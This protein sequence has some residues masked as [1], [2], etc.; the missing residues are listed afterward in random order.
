MSTTTIRP[1][2]Y[3]YLIISRYWHDRL[4]QLHGTSMERLI[5]EAWQPILADAPNDRTGQPGQHGDLVIAWQERDGAA[6]GEPLTIDYNNATIALTYLLHMP[7]EQLAH[8]SDEATEAK[9]RLLEAISDGSPSLIADCLIDLL[10]HLDDRAQRTALLDTITAVQRARAEQEQEQPDT[11]TAREKAA[12][13]A[14]VQ[15]QAAR[16]A[17]ADASQLAEQEPTDANRAALAAALAATGLAQTAYNKATKQLST[18]RRQA[19]RQ[20]RNQAADDQA[21]P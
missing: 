16:R 6:I 4:I 7:I 9:Y 2:T 21:Q 20:A 14:L 8:I 12:E 3:A 15:L 17:E 5:A 19:R 10:P 1:A 18:A 11:L 13:L